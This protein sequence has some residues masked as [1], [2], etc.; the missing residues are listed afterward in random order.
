[1]GEGG[2]RRGMG[3][4]RREGRMGEEGDEYGMGIALVLPYSP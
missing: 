3:M 2:G 4:Q 1:M